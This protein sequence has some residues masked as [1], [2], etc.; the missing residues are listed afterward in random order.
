[1]ER[2]ER[3]LKALD[4]LLDSSG[5]YQA[6]ISSELEERLDAEELGDFFYKAGRA[7]G[8]LGDMVGNILSGGAKVRIPVRTPRGSAARIPAPA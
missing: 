6:E 3:F 7:C 4:N 2:S 1:M 5:E 8:V